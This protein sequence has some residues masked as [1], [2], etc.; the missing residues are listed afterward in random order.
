MCIK[1]KKDMRG[2]LILELDCAYESEVINRFL[3]ELRGEHKSEAFSYEFILY[4]SKDGM[5]FFM[6]MGNPEW[7]PGFKKKFYEKLKQWK[8]KQEN[9]KKA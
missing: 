1:N 7:L 3:D 8:E 9:L 5:P 2:A 6:S 4:V